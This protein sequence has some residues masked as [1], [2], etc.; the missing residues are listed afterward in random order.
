MESKRLPTDFLPA[1]RVSPEEI[2][3]QHKLFSVKMFIREIM[4]S[5]GNI[6]LI[7]NQERQIVFHNSALA[8]MLCLQENDSILGLRPGEMLHCQHADNCES[9]CGTTVFCQTCGA[10]RA[11]V[12][13]QH[14]KND[15]Q[16]CR[17][18]QVPHLTALD[19]RVKSR[20]FRMNGDGFTV[21][22][23]ADISAENRRR[24]M[25]RIFFHDI[26]NTAWGVQGFSSML[27]I[28][29]ESE[30]PEINATIQRLSTVLID[31]IKAQR[32]LTDAETNELSLELGAI[33]TGELLE[34]VK[35]VCSNREF[36]SGKILELEADSEDLLVRSDRTL[37]RR[38]LINLV[39]NAL[40]ASD[41]KKSVTLGC[42]QSGN[43]IE[44]S[45]HNSEVM[46]LDVQL[47]VFQR[48]FS[49]KGRGRGLG[50]YSVKLLTER[51]LRGEVG[52]T[53][54][55]GEGTIFRVTVP[56]TIPSREPTI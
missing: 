24:A 41:P 35:R 13:A 36:S 29:D 54:R 37:L 55:P 6:M 34:E 53:S 8:D 51:Y 19:L 32:L 45:V 20:P 49:T 48:S 42:R 1:E 3:R 22:D 33:R 40:E 2:Q 52:F 47:Q 18:I 4:D 38:V 30:L 50:T 16:E 28:A 46:P 5:A 56:Q 10:A 15:L 21:L 27:T 9:G 17:L 12:S 7:L 43:A 25:E 11:I 31:E 39:K 44:F 26:M 23:V 14:G